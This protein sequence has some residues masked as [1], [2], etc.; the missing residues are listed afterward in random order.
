LRAHR[1]ATSCLQ[2]VLL[3]VLLLGTMH[4]RECIVTSIRILITFFSNN[5]VV[6][7]IFYKDCDA[8][9]VCQTK[10][11][12]KTRIR[13]EHSNNIKLNSSKHFVISEHI[14]QFLHSLGL[15]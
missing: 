14:L 1:A 10:R 5:N 8:S 11:Q 7:K 2:G 9:Y 15:G 3:A 12:L 6:Y 4:F 13:K